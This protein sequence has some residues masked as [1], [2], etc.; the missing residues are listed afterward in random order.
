[1]TVEDS[2]HEL[3]TASYFGVLKFG[4]SYT[5]LVYTFLTFPI[6]FQVNLRT[7]GAPL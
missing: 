1:M 4:R 3:D 5:N 6:G 2:L 7:R